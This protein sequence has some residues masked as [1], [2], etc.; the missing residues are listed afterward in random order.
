MSTNGRV[1]TL[2]RLPPREREVAEAVIAGGEAAAADV[3]Q[4][5]SG[6]MSNSAVRSMLR[7]LEAK[8]VLRK[9]SEG[10]RYLYRPALGDPEV[11]ELLVRRLA[12]QHFGGSLPDLAAELAR[13]MRPGEAA[14]PTR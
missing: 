13:I 1:P 6:P 8:G 14:R 3:L 9:R 7:R 5:I 2:Q 4:R 11:R 10:K 12:E